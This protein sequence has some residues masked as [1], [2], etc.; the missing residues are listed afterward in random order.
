MRLI[1]SYML[2]PGLMMVCLAGTEVAMSL[3]HGVLGFNLIYVG[4]A[5]T[6]A[7]LERYMPHERDWLAQDGQMKADLAHT[8]LNKGFVQVIVV[9]S[10]ITGFAHTVGSSGLQLW[11]AA[12]PLVPQIMLGLVIMEFGLY[13]K[14]RLSHEKAWLWPFHAVH[15]SVLRLW[16]FNTGRF[17]VVDTV[18][19]LLFSLPLMFLLGAPNDIFSWLAAI[20]A[21]IGVLTHCNVEMRC[22]FLTL[23]FNTPSLHRWHHSRDLSEGNKNYGENI[24]LFDH[25]FGTY[26]YAYRRPPAN[27]G[28]SESMPADFIGQ[29]KAPFLTPKQSAPG[30]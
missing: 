27:I 7:V 4:L 22:G 12:W 30:T 10:T 13:W 9:V 1:L 16:F 2:W 29:L 8:L 23:L 11:P 3:G 15:H 20:T 24:T 17:H 6:L 18:M 5:L 21:F 28:I 19:S 25:L 26:F 14:H